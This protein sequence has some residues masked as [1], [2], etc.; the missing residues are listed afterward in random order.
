MTGHSWA[1]KVIPKASLPDEDARA[2]LQ[3]E[4]TAMTYLV[5]P[6][7][8][9]LEDSFVDN[10]HYYL[11]MEVVTGGDLADFIHNSQSQCRER[12]AAGL[13]FQI[14]SGIQY[15]HSRGVAHRDLKP[16]NILL[17]KD[18]DVKIADFG[19]CHFHS[20]DSA[21]KTICGT[22]VYLAPECLTGG[23]YDGFARDI[24]SLGVILYELVTR[25]FPWT[26]ENGPLMYKQILSGKY[27]MPK[28]ASPIC[29]ELIARL[30]K[31]RPTDRPTAAQ[32]LE[33]NWFKLASV[34]PGM[35]ISVSGPALCDLA[36]TLDKDENNDFGS[37]SP[38]CRT[39]KRGDLP[40]LTVPIIAT[41]RPK[42]LE[43]TMSGSIG[44]PTRRFRGRVLK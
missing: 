10:L 34:K 15:C 33:S 22:A 36:A 42:F 8:V 21:M 23:K 13:F 41:P 39:G 31:V 30:L 11:V 9:H 2:R 27:P 28:N 38:L 4:I 14:V 29:T 44:T 26:I 40:K 18:H 37:I 1:I 6:N 35:R 16:Q 25:E 3:R 17:T 19:L 20:P 24:W 5:H 32:I 12:V 43:K 7:I